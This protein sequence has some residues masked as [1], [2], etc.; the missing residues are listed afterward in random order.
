MPS[1][2]STPRRAEGRRLAGG[3]AVAGGP[4]AAGQL[5]AG[6]TNCSRDSGTGPR[7]SRRRHVSYGQ[8][9]RAGIVTSHHL[10]PTADAWIKVEALIQ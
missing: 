2:E 7:P 10:S 8:A 4:E 9:P 6:A 1:P 5:V 3:V